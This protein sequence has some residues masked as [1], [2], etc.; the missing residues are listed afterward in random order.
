[1]VGTTV[2]VVGATVVVV[3]ATVVV[4]GATVVVVGDTVVVVGATVVVVGATVVVVGATVVV[5]G[6]TV[7]VVGAT[8]VV[9]VRESGRSHGSASVLLSIRYPTPYSKV[10]RE[11]KLDKGLNDLY[12]VPLGLIVYI[13]VTLSFIELVLS[14][15]L[16][17]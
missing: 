11:L 3:G 2:V 12:P 15:R 13:V 6:A 14:R 7:V 10:V 17:P 8:V 1:V 9:A 5:V 16:S 4:V